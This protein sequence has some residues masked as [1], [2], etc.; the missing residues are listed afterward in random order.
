MIALLPRFGLTLAFVDP[1]NWQISFDTISKLADERRVDLLVS[2]FGG[3]MLRVAQL[4]Q[5]RLDAFFGTSTWKTD[6]RFLDAGGRPTL[7]GLLKCYREQLASI[8]YLDTMS[9]R[10]IPVK[11]S[12]NVTMYLMAFFSKHPLGYQ[13]WDKITSVD[14]GGQI[15]IPW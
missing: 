15:A 12:K 5:P 7:S 10:E 3:S 9:V 14:E 11:N 8:G 13:F 4:D 1:T 2:F 6:P